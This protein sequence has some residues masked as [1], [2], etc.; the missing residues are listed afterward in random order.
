MGEYQWYC[1]ALTRKE[2]YKIIS[3]YASDGLQTMNFP[4]ERI[5]QA[6]TLLCSIWRYQRIQ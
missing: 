3:Y 1:Q 4:M 5:M 2:P 6:P